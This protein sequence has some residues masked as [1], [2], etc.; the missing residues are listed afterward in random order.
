[1]A[2]TS[3]EA[4]IL[5]LLRRDPTAA[6]GE[7]A[8]RLRITR[9]SVAVH[10]SAL[11][12]KG[13]ITGRA[14]VLR[15][16]A[17][18]VVA[19]GANIDIKAR[20]HGDTVSG[21]SN[22]GQATVSVGGVGRNIA[23]NLSQLG[24]PV[25]LISV[26]GE[27]PE[28]DRLLRE[29]A[30]SGVDVAAVKRGRGSTGFYSAV[31]DRTGELVLGVSAMDILDQLT[32]AELERGRRMI[33]GAGFLVADCNLDIACLRWLQ[34]RATRSGVPLLI[35]PVSAPKSARLCELL[36]SG[37]PVHTATPNLQQI[38]ALTGRAL[39]SEADIRRAAA[40]LHERNVAHLLI[41]LGARGAL[42]SSRNGAAARQHRIPPATAETRDVTGG[43]DA[44]V[45][46]YVAGIMQ[47]KSA[48]DAALFGQ[49]AAGMAVATAETVSP[50]IDSDI[51][52]KRAADLK[53][54]METI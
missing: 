38:E 31:L 26:V 7:I 34:A 29:T 25:K 35:E 49:A 54:H 36:E 20:I 45:A 23:H 18:A 27:D 52:W 28:G 21:T 19:G 1:M 16:A 41:G 43:G 15:S 37:L 17:Y 24:M 10:L 33:D 42:L 12:R 44:L 40:A 2:L 30:A 39:K 22:P 46:G 51:L 3:R 13:E 9:S 14:Y 48:L 32:P 5:E 47:G 11:A 8:A 53:R 4:E 50:A 6:P